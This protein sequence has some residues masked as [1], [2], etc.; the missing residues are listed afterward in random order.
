M[1][2]LRV[3]L[4]AMAVPTP[5]RALSCSGMQERWVAPISARSLQAQNTPV[6]PNWCL[7][8]AMRYQYDWVA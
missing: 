3:V 5:G 2:A 7:A 6:Q 4:P 8:L 1:S